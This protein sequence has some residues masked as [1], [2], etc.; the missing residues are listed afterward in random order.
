MLC[1]KKKALIANWVKNNLKVEFLLVVKEWHSQHHKTD[2][3]P[4]FPQQ[5]PE[6]FVRTRLQ[7]TKEKVLPNFRFS[8]VTNLENI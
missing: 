6:A 7:P 3:P 1:Q 8:F 5:G 4:F 2:L